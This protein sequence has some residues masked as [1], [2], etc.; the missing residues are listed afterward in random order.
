MVAAGPAAQVIQ[1][2]PAEH[3]SFVRCFVQQKSIE[4]G[5]GEAGDVCLA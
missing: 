3:C 4:Q 5:S 2:S 1:R